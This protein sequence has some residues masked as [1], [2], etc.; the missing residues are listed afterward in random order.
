[1]KHEIRIDGRRILAHRAVM[2]AY[3]GRRLLTNEVVHHIN[4]DDEDNRVENLMLTD[5]A[6]HTRIHMQQGDLPHIG[7][8]SNRM[9]SCHPARRHFA[10]EL[11]YQ[12][13]HNKRMRE[14]RKA[15][16][17]E[18]KAKRD[19]QRRVLVASV[20]ER[21]GR[22]MFA[23]ERLWH[24]NGKT[25]DN[26]LENIKVVDVR[27]QLDS[28]RPH[29][30]AAICHPDRLHKSHGLCQQCY[31][32]SRKQQGREAMRR[33]RERLKARQANEVSTCME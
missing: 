33:Y 6:E 4:G 14:H 15:H 8:H 20:E 22:K 19:Q 16:S 32:A 13:Y 28:I 21:M 27:A 11:C 24:I 29:P 25:S 3:L 5:I 7:A 1:M 12:C 26:S 30:K 10:L 23:W 9:A 2:E 18:I 31:T 17:K